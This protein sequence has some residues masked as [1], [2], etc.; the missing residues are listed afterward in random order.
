ML[1]KQFMKKYRLINNQD[2]NEFVDLKSTNLQEC[3]YEALDVFNWSI[4]ES[5]ELTDDE[6][7]M[8]FQFAQA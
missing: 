2:A 1:A 6:D 4:V 3:V 5:I 8:V 7:Q